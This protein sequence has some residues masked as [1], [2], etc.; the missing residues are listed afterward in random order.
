VFFVISGMI[1]NTVSDLNSEI[2][3]VARPLILNSGELHLSRCVT[4]G[5]LEF[6]SPI[7]KSM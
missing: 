1:I 5:A 4:G 7:E 6:D 2:D 3:R